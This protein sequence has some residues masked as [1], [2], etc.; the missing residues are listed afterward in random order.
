[1]SQFGFRILHDDKLG[2]QVEFD[3]KASDYEKETSLAGFY[4]L[5][6][7]LIGPLTALDQR[8]GSCQSLKRA[9]ATPCQPLVLSGE[10]SCQSLKRALP[11][12]ASPLYSRVKS[13]PWVGLKPNYVEFV[14]CTPTRNLSTKVT[15]PGKSS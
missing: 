15:L 6:T 1:M 5:I 13:T 11:V 4:T 9:L 10:G 2:G 14:R 12:P 3:E 8:K 7:T